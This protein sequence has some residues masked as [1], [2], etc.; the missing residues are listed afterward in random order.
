MSSQNL[1]PTYTPNIPSPLN[2]SSP[3][4]LP[5]RYGRGCDARVARKTSGP[6]SPTQKLMRQKAAV[7][8]KSMVVRNAVLDLARTREELDRHWGGQETDCGLRGE[9]ADDGFV[10][11]SVEPYQE[12]D[13]GVVG[14]DMEKQPLV[15]TTELRDAGFSKLAGEPCRWNHQ[16]LPMLTR[17]RLVVVVGIVCI[18]GIVAAARLIDII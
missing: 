13:L 18:V 2:P 7:A 3:E 16:P 6:L 8:W 12:V 4:T 9:A 15:E 17:R 10:T 1:S 14:I 11:L 5:R